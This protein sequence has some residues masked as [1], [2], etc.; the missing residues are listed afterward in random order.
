MCMSWMHVSTHVDLDGLRARAHVG[1][2]LSDVWLC[3]GM[4]YKSNVCIK[5]QEL[6]IVFCLHIMLTFRATQTNHSSLS[7]Q[8]VHLLSNKNNAL[9]YVS[10]NTHLLHQRNV[11]S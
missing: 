4:L 3:P 11:R 9:N 2:W 1:A 7:P 10:T 6:N 5:H 8:N